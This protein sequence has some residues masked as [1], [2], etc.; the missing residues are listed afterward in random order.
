[1][2]ARPNISVVLPTHDGSRHLDESIGSVVA[3]THKAW[4]LIVVDDASGEAC[5]QKIESWVARDERIRAIHLPR[6]RK[7]PGALNE[8]FRHARG[9]Y[10]TWTSD[11]N[12][13]HPSALARLLEE[14]ESHPEID[15]VHSDYVRMGEGGERLGPSRVGPAEQLMDRNG[16]GPCFLYRREVHEELGGYDEQLFLAEDY[17]FWLRAS[18]QF[19]FRAIHECLYFYRVH[20][21]SLTARHAREVELAAQRA[22]ERQS[23]RLPR[24]TLARLWLRWADASFARN[25]AALGRRQLLRAVCLGR[26]LLLYPGTRSLWIDGLFGPRAG[27]L[28]RRLLGGRT[29]HAHRAA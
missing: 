23:H 22:V 8:G 9:A 12:R 2:S 6:Q 19:G 27:R 11:D 17:D 5:A 1:M 24:E 16:I 10:W 29:R 14:L 25:D 21:G 20:E 18:L 13:Y 26:R 7:L 3:Q 15:V 4:E 28:A